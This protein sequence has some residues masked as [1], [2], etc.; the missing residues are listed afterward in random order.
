[1]MEKLGF[2]V[3]VKLWH[4]DEKEEKIMFKTQFV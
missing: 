3:N 2:E 4:L 1:M